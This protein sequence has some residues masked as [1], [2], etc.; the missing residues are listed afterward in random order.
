MKDDWRYVPYSRG[1]LEKML[2][3]NPEDDYIAKLDG[4]V[5]K[6][7]EPTFS[8]DNLLSRSDKLL[9]RKQKIVL[10]KRLVEGKTFQSIGDDLSC[11]RQNCYEIYH[12]ALS[13]LK[14]DLSW[15]TDGKEE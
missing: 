8:F 2:N 15:M 9:T 3:Y 12:K 7:E 10:Y 14:E 6:G 4:D 11:S 1:A 5:T 13:R